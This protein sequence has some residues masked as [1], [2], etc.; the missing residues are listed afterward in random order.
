[1]PESTYLHGYTQAEQQRLIDQAEFW[2]HTLILPGLSYKAGDFVLDIGC[3]VGAV[4][5]VL[6]SEFLGVRAAGI[7]LEPRQI[8]AARRHLASMN[9]GA[10]LRVGDATALPWPEHAFDH[11]YMMWF[12]EHLKEAVA[13]RVLREALRVLRPGGD[14]AI[15]ETDYTSFHVWP[16]SAD[17]DALARAQHEH[18][19]RQGNPIAGRRLGTL[20][21]N[22]GFGRIRVQTI[23]SH[24]FKGGDGDQGQRGLRRIADYVA[25]FLDP[26]VPSL[27]ALGYEEAQLR[28]AVAHLR[29]L[30]EHPEGAFTATGYKAFAV[31]A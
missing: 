14:I 16:P 15:A 25:G 7:D 24:Y 18:F 21:H 5:G 10:D 28:R 9:I 23:A 11:I 22:A 12:I 8:E 3:G 26:A 31:K 1:M 29:A 4:L 6:A 19:E 27:A 20:L 30:P 2:R 17:W 13:A